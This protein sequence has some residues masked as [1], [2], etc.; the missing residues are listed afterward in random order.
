MIA[1]LDAALPTGRTVS[2]LLTRARTV[3]LDAF[4]SCVAGLYTVAI[5]PLF[6]DANVPRL[7]LLLL[8]GPLGA[9][10]LAKAAASRSSA[11]IVLALVLGSVVASGLRAPEPFA[12]LYGNV[13]SST[14]VLMYTLFAAWWAV[15]RG[16]GDDARAMVPVALTIGVVINAAIGVAQVYFDVREGRAQGL[17]LNPVYYGS[18][19]VGL[20]GYWT[21]RS[22]TALRWGCLALVGALSFAAGISGSRVT[23]VA[24]LVV[25]GVQ[26]VHRR[27]RAASVS[28][29]AV[30]AGLVAA[31]VFTNAVSR[32]GTINRFGS[33]SSIS[34][35]ADVWRYGLSALMERPAFGWGLNQ[36]GRAVHGRFSPEFVRRHRYDDLQ[37]TWVD[38]HNFVVLL[39]VTLGVVGFL[40]VVLFVVLACRGRRDGAL[41][42]AVVAIAITWLLQPASLHSLPIAMLLLGLAVRPTVGPGGEDTGAL[43]AD[44]SPKLVIG[45]PG[46]R[47]LGT[48]FA[49]VL[50]AL[51]ALWTLMST[52][53]VDSAG[54]SG[55][56]EAMQDRAE[57]LFPPDAAVEGY[58]ANRLL[59]AATIPAADTNDLRLASIR[60]QTRAAES[61]PSPQR[62]NG[63]ARAQMSIGDLVGAHRSIDRALELQ[64]WNPGA[65]RL[66]LQ[67]AV[68][69]GDEALQRAAERD[70]C[71]LG[72]PMCPSSSA[73]PPD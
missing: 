27:T 15:G 55:D 32:Q 63:V 23:F 18:V 36:F 3:P 8:L 61:L 33:G 59:E 73:A 67:L 2:S 30:V 26:A 11:A 10:Y 25:A 70:V 41:I 21:V 68:A 64:P 7:A 54:R 48:R 22:G 52:Y 45:D 5:V 43:G 6:V 53:L 60:W 44:D 19:V 20:C 42:A 16:S 28:A 50:G 62:W 46:G 38:P 24:A 13:G 69:Q 14:S 56:V 71:K 35:R 49:L 37:Q 39:L 66:R 4:V 57:L 40:L 29:V 58:V 12:S 9:L 51:L 65:H 31:S 72:L 47:R 17:M 1:E 34:A